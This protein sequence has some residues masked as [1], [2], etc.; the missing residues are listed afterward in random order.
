[1]AHWALEKLRDY[2]SNFPDFQ[3]EKCIFVLY[4]RLVTKEFVLGLDVIF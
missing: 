3:T 2:K 1:M 4:N